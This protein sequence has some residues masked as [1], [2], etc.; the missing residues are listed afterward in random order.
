M[1]TPKPRQQLDALVS[2]IASSAAQISTEYENTG[3][4]APSLDAESPDI[5]QSNDQEV[6]QRVDRA[7]KTLV[8]ACAQLSAIAMRPHRA[9]LN[10]RAYFFHLKCFI[11]NVL[12]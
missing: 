6:N 10:V 4:P 2:L 5:F 7:T 3:L 12:R 9:I 1:A 8:A 11:S